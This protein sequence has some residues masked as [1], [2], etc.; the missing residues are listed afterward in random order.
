MAFFKSDVKLPTKLYAMK[1][2]VKCLNVYR[3]Y[4]KRWVL[5]TSPSHYGVQQHLDTVLQ[6]ACADLRM[7]FAGHGSAFEPLNRQV[8]QS[9]G[10]HLIIVHFS[11]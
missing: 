8:P 7:W 11:P 10:Y 1:K 2:K 6:G 9:A 5:V 3:F 4:G